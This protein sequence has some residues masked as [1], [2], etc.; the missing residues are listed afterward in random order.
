MAKTL[1]Q[2]LYDGEIYPAE[3]IVPKSPE[4]TELLRKLGTEKQYLRER[5]DEMGDMHLEIASLCGYEDF[6]YGF[7]LG[8]GLMIEALVSGNGLSRNNE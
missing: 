8:A 4:Y 5:F 7:R 1:L 2:Q 3:Q 6:A